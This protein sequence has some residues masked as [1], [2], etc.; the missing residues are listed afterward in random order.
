MQC[1]SQ[2]V[3]H[4]TNI[5]KFEANGVQ[6]NR[7]N[8]ADSVYK[9]DILKNEVLTNKDTDKM[10]LDNSK[11]EW[12]IHSI[13]NLPEIE[14]SNTTES[15]EFQGEQTNNESALYNSI[16]IKQEVDNNT[17]KENTLDSILISK[18]K[19]IDS[20]TIKYDQ[21]LSLI[22]PQ[23][24]HLSYQSYII[25]IQANSEKAKQSKKRMKKS[26]LYLGVQSENQ[27]ITITPDFEDYIQ[28]ISFVKDRFTLENH[29]QK[30][31]IKKGFK[32]VMENDKRVVKR[33]FKCHLSKGNSP[34]TNCPFELRYRK[35]MIEGNETETRFYLAYYR[36]I[37]NHP[38]DAE[39]Q[40][41]QTINENDSLII[42]D[43]LT[44]LN[45]WEIAK[46][47]KM[48]STIYSRNILHNSKCLNKK[49]RQIKQ[50]FKDKNDDTQNFLISDEI[51]SKIIE[52][53]RIIKQI[54]KDNLDEYYNQELNLISLNSLVKRSCW[55]APIKDYSK[56]DFDTNFSWITLPAEDK[57][58]FKEEEVIF[59]DS[60]SNTSGVDISTRINN[61]SVKKFLNNIDHDLSEDY[62][63]L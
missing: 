57:E 21:N 42:Y 53:V 25:N 11:Q 1:S 56:Y 18:A 8:T 3:N 44:W 2:Y 23:P 30:L 45:S 32:V 14:F 24:I 19:E 6:W 47:F 16:Q 37:H 20:K 51:D 60:K 52:G 36:E 62:C 17:W 26:N 13:M 28:W 54:Y 27:W 33:N 35:L 58:D 15:N 34:S 63:L 46:Y 39:V 31:S 59:E 43:E 5:T 9:N 55:I 48:L 38:L 12:S 40:S 50:S 29:I 4:I 41:D 22:I 61:R 7:D 10:Q 49:K